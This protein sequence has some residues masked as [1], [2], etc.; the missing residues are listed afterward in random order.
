MHREQAHDFVFLTQSLGFRFA[1]A[2]VVST[3]MEI[4]DDVVQRRGSLPRELARDFN[5]FSD[6]GQALTAVLL[7]H[8]DDVEVGLPNHIL[9]YFRGCGRIPAAHPVVE[10]LVESR[11]TVGAVHDRPR[12]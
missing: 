10:N 9:K 6:I 8:H 1:H 3:V 4:P 11:F 12:S 5:Q 7:R 2:R